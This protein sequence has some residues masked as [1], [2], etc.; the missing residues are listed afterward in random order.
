MHVAQ[1]VFLRWDVARAMT[2]ANIITYDSLDQIYKALTCAHW[3][4]YSSQ[5][6]A[7]K[8]AWQNLT[9]DAAVL[10]D[11]IL[12]RTG[13]VPSGLVV[14]KRVHVNLQSSLWRWC[15]WT[16][17][18]DQTFVSPTDRGDVLIAVHAPDCM[19]FL[20]LPFATFWL[21]EQYKNRCRILS[22]LNSLGILPEYDKVPL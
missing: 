20:A 18:A 1:Q 4:P 14:P 3:S 13:G 10:A 15:L 16:T 9:G 6:E 19:Y 2:P 8:L 21:C 5:Q 11:V 7:R 17:D 12:N 22:L